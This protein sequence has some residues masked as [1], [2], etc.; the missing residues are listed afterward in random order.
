MSGII[1]IRMSRKKTN[2]LHNIVMRGVKVKNSPI[3]LC[4]ICARRYIQTQHKQDRCLFCL[5]EMSD[6]STYDILQKHEESDIM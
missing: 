3:L 1:N 2:K 4:P 6:L 5:R